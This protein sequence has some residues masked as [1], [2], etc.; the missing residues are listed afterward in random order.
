MQFAPL[1]E[2][3]RPLFAMVACCP[4][5][6]AG[7]DCELCQ[8]HPHPVL[9][10]GSLVQSATLAAAVEATSV[11]V[12]QRRAPAADDMDLAVQGAALIVGA[13]GSVVKQSPWWARAASSPNVVKQLSWYWA[14][15]RVVA[16][17]TGE[18]VTVL[19]L[20]D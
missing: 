11:G 3:V 9:R 19:G 1:L 12:F 6:V 10:V 14:C 4:T 18:V 7:A 8:V 15:Q 16:A 20:A 17:G 13:R 2:V 5:W